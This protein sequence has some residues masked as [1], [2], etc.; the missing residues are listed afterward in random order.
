MRIFTPGGR[1]AVRR[2]SERRHRMASA[3][4]RAARSPCCA[5]RP[6]SFRCATRKRSCGS[7][8]APSGRRP[9]STSSSLA[10]P[11]S[12]RL[13]ARR[14]AR[15]GP[16]AGRGRTRRQG[17]SARARSAPRGASP[18]TRPRDRLRWRSARSSGG[19]SRSA[20]AGA[21]R[22]SPGRSRTAG[23]RSAAASC[24]TRCAGSSSAG[25]RQS[26]LTTLEPAYPIVDKR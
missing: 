21:L 20:R 7:P 3:R 17:E 1:V 16:T 19:R 14:V 26:G 25:E 8:R 23:P 24:S 9:S 6:A 4:D 10:P 18:R 22:S 11:T 12:T 5:R 2:A 13:R 15:G